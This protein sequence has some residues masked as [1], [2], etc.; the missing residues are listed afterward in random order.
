MDTNYL[1]MEKVSS[2]WPKMLLLLSL[3]SS[4]LEIFW[5]YILLRGVGLHFKL[6]GIM[7]REEE[8]DSTEIFLSRLLWHKAVGCA[9]ALVLICCSILIKWSGSP[10]PKGGS[11]DPQIF[12]LGSKEKVKVNGHWFGWGFGKSASLHVI[13]VGASLP[14]SYKHVPNQDKS[15]TFGFVDLEK[16]YNWLPK[17]ILDIIDWTCHIWYS[18]SDWTILDRI[19][20]RK[21]HSRARILSSFFFFLFFL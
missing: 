5:H 14:P 19:G 20:L 15:F 8:C 7:R 11:S 9:F 1:P 6:V 2:C 3:L 4:F 16:N 17:W 21:A 13:E 12:V 10:A 18:F